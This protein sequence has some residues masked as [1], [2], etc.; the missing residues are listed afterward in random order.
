[1]EARLALANDGLPSGVQLTKEDEEKRRR[2]RERNKIAASK[3][4]NRKKERTV[5]LCEESEG[6]QRG[7]AELRREMQMLRLEVQ[8][9]TSLLR[10]HACVGTPPGATMNFYGPSAGCL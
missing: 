8:H 9:L 6:L 1:M 5:R 7:N 10:Q 4:R 2:R 3:C